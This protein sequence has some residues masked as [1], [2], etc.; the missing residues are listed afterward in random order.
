[1]TDTLEPLIQAMELQAGA[2]VQL[3]SPFSAA[4]SRAV[5]QGLRAGGALAELALPWAGR[6]LRGVFAD[7]T[8]LRFM[9]ALHCLVLAGKAPD[10]ASFYPSRDAEPHLDS[11]AAL[12]EA[13]ARDHRGWFAEFIKSPP[14]TNEVNR[15]IALGAG[16]LTIA[17]RAA[18]PLRCLEIGASAGL[19]MNWDRFRHDLG[20]LG[21]WGPADSPVR[22]GADWTGAPPPYGVRVEV[23]E[24][25]GCDQNPIDIRDPEAAP[26]LKAYVWPD[27][28]ERM[29]RLA[30][31]IAIASEHRPE[32]ERADA[33]AWTRIHARPVP[34]LASVLYHSV[35]WPY[36][37]AQT[38]ADVAA[39]IA[40][41]GESASEA[42]PFAWLRMEA[43]PRDLA[44]P[45]ELRLTYWPGGDEILLARV[46][47]HGAKVAWTGD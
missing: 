29:A 39:A 30:G 19:N 4:V 25:R 7:A 5:G 36:L 2:C 3:G 17:R 38:Q 40:T 37:P 45:Q 1:M 24:R 9:G 31:A 22:L 20:E 14:Q 16:F 6:D 13:A 43:N 32:V 34:G 8:P 46:H 15:S 33:A 10:L 28:A 47:P 26:R 44:G 18:L 41:A 11:L 21:A 27:Q 12:A 23:A 42:A 35:V